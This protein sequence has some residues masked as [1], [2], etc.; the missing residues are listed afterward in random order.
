MDGG[1]SKE[2]EI[3]EENESGT[4]WISRLCYEHGLFCATHPKLVIF[5][6]A[7]VIFSCR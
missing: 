5:F 1:K 7:M 6:T 4:D 3:V 2:N